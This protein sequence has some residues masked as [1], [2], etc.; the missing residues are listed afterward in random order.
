MSG[1]NIEKNAVVHSCVLINDCGGIYV[2]ADSPNTRIA[3]NLVDNLIG[4]TDGVID[5]RPHTAGIYLDDLSTGMKVEGNSVASAEFGIQVHNAYNNRVKGN[6]FFGSRQYQ[7]L[8]QE[9]TRVLRAAGD[10]YGNS[11]EDNTLVPTKPVIALLNQSTIGKTCNFG[12]F[13][14]NNYSALLSSQIVGVS[15]ATEPYA[16]LRFD[17]WRETPCAANMASDDSSSGRVINPVGYAA[18]RIVGGNI[19]PNGN[20]TAGSIG[21]STWNPKPPYAQ[22]T[23]ENCGVA[24]P[25]LHRSPGGE[26][27]V[28]SSPNFSIQ[29]DVWYRVSFDVRTEETGQPFTVLIRR[30]GWGTNVGYESLMGKAQSFA[31]GSG[32]KRYSFSFKATRSII[33]SDPTTGER[34]ARVDFEQIAPGRFLHISSLEIVPTAALET[35]LNLR[36][37]RNASRNPDDVTCPDENSAPESCANYV[38]LSDQQAVSWPLTLNPLGMEIIFNRDPSLV[39]SDADG[40]A[41][42]QDKCARTTTG[43][44]TDAAGCALGQSP[45]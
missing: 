18:A 5:P 28:L 35:G 33:A 42:M 26:G 15:S 37:L 8:V 3:F 16:Q 9:Q 11:I 31:G 41:D 14:G 30:D 29:K 25:C 20:L 44:V 13:R 45:G 43:E 19:V 7:M 23:F 40:I 32:W 22:L 36:M 12:T 4:N 2:N 21:W 1:S 27:G 6:T 38:R 39:D 34:G 10:L 24:G 17:E